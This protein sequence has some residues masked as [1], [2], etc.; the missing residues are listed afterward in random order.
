MHRYRCRTRLGPFID[1]VS[2]KSNGSCI[3]RSVNAVCTSLSV[4]LNG[5]R[6]VASKWMQMVTL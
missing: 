3:V 2:G 4:N 5:I 1:E 6:R